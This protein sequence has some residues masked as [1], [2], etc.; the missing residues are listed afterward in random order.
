[1]CIIMLIKAIKYNTINSMG[2]KNTP[3]NIAT[4]I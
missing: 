2:G 3:K 1:M 4:A